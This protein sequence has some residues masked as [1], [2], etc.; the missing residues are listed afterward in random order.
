M[1]CR[2]LDCCTLINLYCGWGGIQNLHDFGDRWCIGAQALGEAKYVREFGADGSVENRTID[3]SHLRSQFPLETL[4]VE[5]DEEAALLVR[6]A[7]LLDD[8]EAEG[9]TLAALRN[10]AFC[11]D[12]AIVHRA[13]RE[14]GLTVEIVST[15]EL[16]Q[17]WTSDDKAR[18]EQLPGIVQR[19]SVLARFVPHRDSPYLAWW[20]SHLAA[21]DP[22]KWGR[23]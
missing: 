2:V 14:L 23:T 15:A 4:A 12:D 1:T 11:S 13:V 5:S 3:A 20:R 8:G 10:K 18:Q 9:L 19:I 16:L 6:T 21:A 22:K 7:Q 17:R